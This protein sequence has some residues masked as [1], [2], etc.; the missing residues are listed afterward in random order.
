MHVD[1]ELR[2]MA[3]NTLQNMLGEFPEW[4]E[5]IIIAEITL[6][7]NQLTVGF[8]LAVFLFLFN[9]YSV[10]WAGP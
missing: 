4:R 5:Q 8:S 2:T 3:G 10:C 9:P 7:H 1:E 6:L